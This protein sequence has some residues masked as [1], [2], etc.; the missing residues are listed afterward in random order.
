MFSFHDRSSPRSRARVRFFLNQVG[1]GK[2]VLLF[3]LLYALSLSLRPLESRLHANGLS[4]STSKSGYQVPPKSLSTSPCRSFYMIKKGQ[5]GNIL[6]G[7]S[8][9][10]Q[11]RQVKRFL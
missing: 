9:P 8:R 5:I 2:S 6:T 4:A 11:G 10:R 3:V 7:L 1:S